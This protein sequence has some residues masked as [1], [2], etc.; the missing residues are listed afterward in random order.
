MTGGP[1]KLSGTG[2]YG[3]EMKT[4]SKQKRQAGRAG[5]YAAGIAILAAVLAVA[6]LLFL[7]HKDGKYRA[8]IGK[9]FLT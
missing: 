4:V 1:G 7:R 5:K 2:A 3:N 8:D 6:G 9:L